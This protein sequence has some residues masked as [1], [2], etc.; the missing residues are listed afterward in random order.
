MAGELQTKLENRGYKVFLDVDEISSGAFPE[1]I[2]YAIEG[3]QDFLL[4]LAPGTLDCCSDE[5][6]WVRR[7]IMKAESLGKNLIG[8]MLPGFVMPEPD[9]L[10][11]P[12]QG[13]PTKQVF[14]WSHEYR[15]ASFEKIEENL[16]SAKAKK[17]RNRR[18]RL[19]LLPVVLA[20]VAATTVLLARK[21]KAEPTTLVENI[22]GE[23]VAFDGH[24]NK[25]SRLA[26]GLPTATEFEEKFLSFID[27]EEDFRNLISAIAEC[28][29]AM[30]LKN[31]HP[32]RIN[33]SYDIENRRAAL[34]D[35]RSAYMGRIVSD[36]DDLIR[37]GGEKFAV[38]D[39]KIA[40][41]LALPSDMRVLDSL[42]RLISENVNMEHQ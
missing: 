4:V 23:A 31:Q 24:V 10:P 9:T 13:L 27:K 15:T 21:P 12:L 6:D 8:V 2:D 16:L 26:E 41:I 5:N 33:D 7:E 17:Q 3:C 39:L 25:A 20:L 32:D 19:A 11:R 22:N 28:D 29:T 30:M 1:Q 14:V 18:M 40:K 42:G 36:I 38:Q 34:M 35:L 37:E